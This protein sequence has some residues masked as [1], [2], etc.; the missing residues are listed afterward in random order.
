MQFAKDSFYVALR[1]RLAVV[2]PERTITVD[3]VSRT[4][5]VVAENEAPATEFENAFVLT[6]G[7][8]ELVGNGTKLMKLACTISYGT[9]GADSTNGDRG[10]ALGILDGELLAIS[11]PPRVQKTDY[12]VIP[13]QSLGTMLFWTDP[14]FGGSEDEAGR[15]SR[16]AKTT[17]YFYSEVQR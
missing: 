11:Q 4:G 2:N 10:R 5:V 14:E 12:T 17:V 3:G 16:T 13:P 8:A 9:G 15:I 7:D 1:D 6:W